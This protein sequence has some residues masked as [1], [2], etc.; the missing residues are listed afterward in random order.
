[1]KMSRRTAVIAGSIATL[2]VAGTL[3]AG[4]AFAKGHG[5]RNNQFSQSQG[6]PGTSTSGNAIGRVGGMGMHETSTVGGMMGGRGHGMDMDRDHGMSNG[7]ARGRMLHSEGVVA[8]TDAAGAVTYVTVRQ[9]DG[10]VTAASDT[11]IT[12]KSDD[13]YT[14]TWPIDANTKIVRN[15][16]VVKGSAFVSGDIVEVRG[17][18]SAAGVVT[19]NDIHNHAPRV[20]PTPVATASASTSGASA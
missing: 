15:G 17:I 18:V 20:A 14:A 16:A 19:T 7:I 8:Q 4:P 1:M 5:N 9:Q 2:A 13:G 12:V 11:S 6:A 3:V 10:K